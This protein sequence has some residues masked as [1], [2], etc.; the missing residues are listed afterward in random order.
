MDPRYSSSHSQL[1]GNNIEDDQCDHADPINQYQLIVRPQYLPP[2]AQY[3]AD[4]QPHGGLYNGHGFG[5]NG[6]QYG[7][8][9]YSGPDHHPRPAARSHAR[10]QKIYLYTQRLPSVR[11]VARQAL[12]AAVRRG[13]FDLDLPLQ[14][15]ALL[16]GDYYYDAVR[17]GGPDLKIRCFGYRERARHGWEGERHRKVLL[18]CTELGQA[19]MSEKGMYRKTC[20]R[21][22]RMVGLQV[23]D[24]SRSCRRARKSS[25]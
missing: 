4:H 25:P 10:C 6:T 20:L 14:Q 8:G 3:N 21:S 15:W 24:Q 19:Q 12:E 16:V 23:A 22:T 2:P 11:R 1:Q 5:P 13:H 17:D 18:G 7:E 9:A